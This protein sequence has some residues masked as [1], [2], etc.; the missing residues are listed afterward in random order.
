MGLVLG[1]IQGSED[2]QPLHTHP[3]GLH[4][5]TQQKLQIR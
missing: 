3:F 2:L 1:D 5:E 4:A